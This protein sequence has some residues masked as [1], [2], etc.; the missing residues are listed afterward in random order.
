MLPR[1]ASVSV[2]ALLLGVGGCAHTEEVETGVSEAA[3]TR[4]DLGP[5]SFRDIF[6]TYARGA[7]RSESAIKKLV[8]LATSDVIDPGVAL[9]PTPEGTLAELD[10]A[11][12]T[13]LPSDLYERGDRTPLAPAR[14]ID[15]SMADRGGVTIVVL[16]EL[17]DELAAGAPFQEVLDLTDSTAAV[18]WR[19]AL[20]VAGAAPET[21]DNAFSLTSLG[22]AS[23]SLGD[24]VKVASIDHT[25]GQP[26]VRIIAL[27][28]G[29]HS[30][31]SMGSLSDAATI[32]LRRLDK[33]FQVMGPIAPSRFYA[34]GHGRGASMALEVAS[35]VHTSSSSATWGS[36]FAGVMSLGGSIYGSPLA[37]GAL[38]RTTPTGKIYRRFADLSRDLETCIDGETAEVR[39][40][41]TADN[42]VAWN[43]GLSDLR[44][45]VSALPV[46]DELAWEGFA[47][48]VSEDGRFGRRIHRALADDALRLTTAVPTHCTDVA[49]FKK[50]YSAL[51]AGILSD[52]TSARHTW[53]QT[54]TIPGDMK[55]FALTS[56]MGNVSTSSTTVWPLTTNTTA[57]D[58]NTIDMKSARADFYDVFAATGIALNDGTLPLTRA[59][60]WP[61]LMTQENVSQPA[62]RTYFLGT[63]GTYHGGLVHAE[64]VETPGVGA[65]PFPRALLLKALA[66][67]AV[68]A[69]ARE[70]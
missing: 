42:V 70:P 34:L 35:R 47:T 2:L 31:E 64:S 29:F 17:M 45:L 21:T 28:T 3:A 39:Q 37:D 38:I 19:D 58:P 23:T 27:Q 26:L 43:E 54:H 61:A 9:E 67:F 5:L 66:R 36:K 57:Y 62:I 10:R 48:T 52:S 53:W 4:D 56:V 68:E 11:F 49:R 7:G 1:F 16:P 15:Q 30:L 22:A 60:F 44:S 63:L 12:S 33:V 46:N 24:L 25:D 8:Y 51:S 40:Q 6:A 18:E 59:R 55:L 41:K 20:T 13:K 32:V 65:N 50:L 69:Q 14:D